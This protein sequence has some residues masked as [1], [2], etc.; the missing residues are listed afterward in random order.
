MNLAKTW[1]VALNGI[2]PFSLEVE[3]S[4][5]DAAG[6]D[7]FLSIVGVP[8]TTVRESK[9][10]V[11]S[12]ITATGFH[13]PR[14]STTISLAPAGIKKSGSALDL[15]IA[16]ALIASCDPNFPSAFLHETIFIGEL[17]LDGR[18]RSVNGA[19]A[20]AL[21]AREKGFKQIYIATENAKEAAIAEGVKVY[22]VENLREVY[23]SLLGEITIEPIKTDLSTLFKSENNHN[24]VDF[25]H[26]KGQ[27]ALRRGL[28]I[29]ACGGHNLI[30]I[31]P[32]GCG[33]T[34][35]A[36]SFSTILPRLDL[37]EALK[38]TQIHSIAGTL[39]A[40][41]ALITQR[42]YRSPHHTV[43]EA[44]LLG[45][46]SNP[47]PGEVSLAHRGVLFLDELPE[48]K[49]STLEVLRQPMES[50]D[51]Q[52]SR[53]SG[54]CR[55]PADFTLIAAMNPCPCG[56]WGSSQK[57][58]RCNSMQIQRYR[59]RISGPLLDRID[60]HLEINPLSQEE[61]M[62]KANGES[63][64]LIR[65]RVE[66]ARALQH[67]RF[68]NSRTNSSLNTKELEDVCELD[69]TSRQLLQQAINS[70]DLS[71]RAYD[72]IL[73]VSRTIADLEASESIQAE[74]IGEAIQ[75]RSLDRKL[76]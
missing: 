71:A 55:F 21:H 8:D 56:F 67:Q 37:E 73:R 12:A 46:S 62:T 57:E 43:S 60:L 72:R 51:V 6:S 25:A 42:P 17:A 28:E 29:A 35:M 44:G 48:Y 76:W 53:A 40:H 3:V 4:T 66:K 16:M 74:H 20:M 13:F 49:R 47:R 63:S 1:S 64:L 11:R 7:N 54:T 34:L 58:C 52:I 45:G 30:M 75:Y 23:H 26:I 14:G 15:P 2:E 70:L 9:E 5:N 61:L 24:A 50:G 31:G 68:G 69:Q 36:R 22:P 41:Q 32:P 33:K 38:V 27:Q 10:R 18:I 65:E 19:L 59:N 39:E